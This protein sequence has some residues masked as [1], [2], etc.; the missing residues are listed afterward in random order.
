M[1]P[2]I[3]VPT[4]DALAPMLTEQIAADTP[5]SYQ[6]EIYGD[7]TRTSKVE[8]NLEEEITEKYEVIPKSMGVEDIRPSVVNNHR[9]G[10]TISQLPGH[11]DI[12]DA[13]SPD[14]EG[15][16]SSRNSPEEISII[17]GKDCAMEANLEPIQT[18]GMFMTS[19]RVGDRTKTA[20]EHH[21]PTNERPGFCTST[22]MKVQTAANGILIKRCVELEV[23]ASSSLEVG[24]LQSHNGIQEEPL[25]SQQEKQVHHN[26]RVTRKRIS[27]PLQNPQ[28][29]SKNDDMPTI[30]VTGFDPIS[31]YNDRKN[32]SWT[33]VKKFYDSQTN[34]GIFEHNSTHYQVLISP[35]GKI[36]PIKTTYSY[37]ASEPGDGDFDSWLQSS[38]ARLYVHLGTDSNLDEEPS[39]TFR[40]DKQAKNGYNG[41]WTRDRN[42]E[43]FPGPCISS[44]PDNICT[45]FSDVSLDELVERL[46]WQVT[47]KKINGSFSSSTSTE[48]GHFLCN[49][50]YYRSL[51]YANE[52]N[53]DSSPDQQSYVIFVH[54]PTLLKDKDGNECRKDIC[55]SPPAAAVL[56][57]IVRDLLDIIT[58]S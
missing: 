45:P 58:P 50:L 12:G 28:L 23:N 21:V 22:I 42:G 5:S 33:I 19:P 49:F 54:I 6:N 52:R 36:E 15:K 32:L 48:V 57:L 13:D 40:F 51:Y 30:V 14:D 24:F 1:D 27:N 53:K 38:N 25:R 3:S 10:A 46:P 18:S 11:A 39:N 29:N 47:D 26:P 8:D 37:V 35:D 7:S 44:G 4:M 17:I 20:D 43:R 16:V 55:G 41:Y 56:A 31:N 9:F 34:D 2:E